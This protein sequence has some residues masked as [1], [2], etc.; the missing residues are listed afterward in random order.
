MAIRYSVL[1]AGAMGSIF[2]ARLHLAGCEVE[3][4]N[5]SPEHSEAIRKKGLLAHFDG[6]SQHI[7]IPACTVDQARSA[8]V[9]IIFTKSY[10]IETALQQLPDSL[11]S[12]QVVTLQNGLGNAERV[13]KW[14]GLARTIEGVTMMPAEFI[15]PGEVASS[16]P[17]ETWLY[18]ANGQASEV[19]ESIAGDFNKA[20]I[21]S[22][23]SAEIKSHIWQKAC[24]NLAMNALCAL[25]NGS[26]GLLHQYDDGKAL[27]HE[28]ADESLA[29]AKASGVTID[30]DKVHALIDY[31]CASHTWHKPSML[32]D[33]EHQRS[34]EIEAL[35][36]YVEQLA[37][38]LGLAIPLN[39]MLARLIRLRQASPDF[40]AQEH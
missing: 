11:K 39:R 29:V 6:K 19:V 31:A 26:P 36:G 18:H 35:N 32:Q 38:D 25:T 28:I 1:G 8:D 9:V 21:V 13:A 7:D 33:M 3:L 22:T 5:R 20:G 27:A 4:L 15:G 2:G 30:A 34:T 16:D 23:V 37:E 40:W 17:A 12:A 10:Q 24:F 14:V